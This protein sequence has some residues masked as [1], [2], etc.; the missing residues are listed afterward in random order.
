[1]IGDGVTVKNGAFICDLVT[2]GDEVFIGPN[3]TFT[4]D[5][6]PRAFLKRG[7]D[8]LLPTTVDHGA[9]IGAGAVIVCGT[10]IGRF[11]FV[12]AGA[13]V[14]DDVAPH[15][16]VVGSPARQIAWVCRCGE[17]LDDALTC[18]RCNRAYGFDADGRLAERA[19]AKVI[20][21]SGSPANAARPRGATTAR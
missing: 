6:K 8:E 21:L 4:N 18:D 13:V 3:S 19:A 5:L 7:L 10:V 15:A 20:D 2:I 17:R 12:G 9:T 1:V 16:L 11:A 14:I